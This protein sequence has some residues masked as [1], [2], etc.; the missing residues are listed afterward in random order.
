MWISD[1][2]GAGEVAN[3]L[4][5]TGMGPAVLHVWGRVHHEAETGLRRQS[6]GRA[7]STC[8]YH[9][10]LRITRAQP[11]CWGLGLRVPRK[12]LEMTG[13]L[14]LEADADQLVHGSTAAHVHVKQQ[15]SFFDP[16]RCGLS[17]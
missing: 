15:S 6:K 12:G 10:T 5:E 11:D 4:R 8:S 2:V 9:L 17:R 14:E 7:V 1:G 13:G 16:I 3:V